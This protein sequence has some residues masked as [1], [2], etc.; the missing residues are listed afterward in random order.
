[1]FSFGLVNSLNNDSISFHLPPH[2]DDDDIGDDGI[3]E[4]IISQVFTYNMI[5][6]II[7]D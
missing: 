1:M 3:V 2:D 6:Y 4:I 5:I 7:Y